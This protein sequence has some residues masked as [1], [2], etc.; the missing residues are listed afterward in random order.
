M[1]TCFRRRRSGTLLPSLPARR[2]THSISS[3]RRTAMGRS[4]RLKFRT[5]SYNHAKILPCSIVYV[6]TGQG[7]IPDEIPPDDGWA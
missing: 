3:G 1:R 2:V 7:H 6:F 4:R 5:V